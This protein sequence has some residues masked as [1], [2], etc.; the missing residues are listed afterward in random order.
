MTSRKGP[1]FR[2]TGLPADRSDKELEV[3]LRTTINENFSEKETPRPRFSTTIIPS[4]YDDLERAALVEFH[5][6]VPNFLNDLVENPLG[7]WQVEMGD[8]D[9]NFDKHFF[10]FT[11]LYQPNANPSVTADI[12]AITGLD[13]HAY[14]SWRGKGSLGRM[15]LRDFLSKDLPHCRTMIYGYNSKLSSHGIDT[16]MDYGR[17]LMEELKKIRNS[18]EVSYCELIISTPGMRLTVMEYQLR[19]RPLFFIAHSFGGIILAHCLVKAVQTNEDDHPTIA[20]LHKATYGMLLFAIPHK[21]LV[22]SDIQNMVT[23]GGTHPR[24]ALLDQIKV[25]SDLLA[26]QLVDFKNLIR[27]RKIVSFYETGQTRQL[28]FNTQAKRWERTGSFVTA[29]DTDSALLQLPDSME[30]KIPLG[31]DHSMIVKFDARQSPGYASSRDR[32]KAF[33]EDARKVVGARFYLLWIKGIPGSGKSTALQYALD[34]YHK[35]PEAG[36]N[37]FTLVF[38]FHHRGSD[39]QQTS[40]GFIRSLLCQILRQ[41]PKTLQDLVDVFSQRTHEIGHHGEGWQ[42]RR[43]ELWRFFEDSVTQILKTRQIWLFVDALD[44][45][46]GNDATDVFLRIR[47]ILRNVPNLGLNRL[48]VCFSSRRY[49]DLDP[50]GNLVI[51]LDLENQEDIS[52][53]VRQQLSHFHRLDHS[54][55]PELIV[56][57]AKSLFLWASIMVGKVLDKLPTTDSWTPLKDEIRHT[58]QELDDLYYHL[59]KDPRP[60]F[61]EIIRWICFASR[62]LL[63]DELRWAVI[64]DVDYGHTSLQACQRSRWFG[65]RDVRFEDRVRLLSHGLA[66]V[67]PQ[68]RVVRFI[69]QSV[70]DFFIDKGGFQSLIS[71]TRIDSIIEDAH[72]RLSRACIRYFAMKEISQLPSHSF[73]DLSSTFPLLDY[74]TKSWVSHLKLCDAESQTRILDSSFGSQKGPLQTWIR[75]FSMIDQHSTHCPPRGFTMLHFLSANHL[76]APLQKLLLEPGCSLEPVN[77]MDEH[78][79]TPLLCAT[80]NGCYDTAK[81]LLD[82]GRADPNIGDKQRRTPLWWAAKNGH[83]EVTR[84]LLCSKGVNVNATDFECGR[85]P[86]TWAAR[87][88]HAWVTGL[89]LGT[90]G[91]NVNARDTEY[92]RAPLTWAARNGN[93][94]VAALI[95]KSND[96]NLEIQDNASRTPIAWTAK[97]GHIDVLKLLL[98]RSLA[99][100]DTKD[101][102][103]HTPVSWAAR[104]GYA[105]VVE[106]LL[107]TSRKLGL[108][109]D[110]ADEDGRTPLSWAA[111][112][113]HSDVVKLILNIRG[114][115]IN[116][117]EG[118]HHTSHFWNLSTRRGRKLQRHLS[119]IIQGYDINS[120]DKFGRTPLGWAAHNGHTETV[121]LLIEANAKINTKDKRGRTPLSMV[122]RNYKRVTGRLL[123]LEETCAGAEDEASQTPLIL[124]SESGHYAVAKLLLESKSIDV[125]TESQDGW[126]TLTWAAKNGHDSLVKLLLDTGKI[127]VNQRTRDDWTPLLLAASK[128]HYAV[129]KLLLDRRAHIN[130]KD[131]DGWTALLFATSNGHDAVVELLLERNADVNTKGQNGRTPLLLASEKGH[132]TSVKLL[133]DMNADINAKTQKGWTPLMWATKNA[134][135]TVVKLLLDRNANVNAKDSEELLLKRKEVDINAKDHNGKTPLIWASEKGFARITDLLLSTGNADVEAKDTEGKT[136]L[137]H[138]VEGAY[139]HITKLLLKKGN[140]DVNARDD[141][142]WTALLIASKTCRK[143]ILKLILDTKKAD[144][145]CKDYWPERTPLLWAAQFG[146]A[147]IVKLL[148]KEENLLFEERDSEHDRTPLIWAALKGRRTVVKLLLESK[149]VNVNAEDCDK[150]TALLWAARNGKADVVK[151]LLSEEEIYLEAKDPKHGR[152]SLIWAAHNGRTDVV[153]AL[154]THGKINVNAKDKEGR[155]PLAWAVTKGYRTVV[156]TLLSVETVDIYSEDT[157]GRTLLS[158]AANGRFD[159]CNVAPL[160]LNKGY[161]KVDEGDHRGRTPLSWAAGHGSE[162]MI[163]LLLNTNLVDVNAK[164]YDGRTP[165]HT[166]IRYM[167]KDAVKALL[168]A[169]DIDI[170]LKDKDGQTPLSRATRGHSLDL[171][172]LLLGTGKADVNTRDDCGRTPLIWAAIEN[173]PLVIKRLLKQKEVDITASDRDGLTA[174]SWAVKKNQRGVVKLLQP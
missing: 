92:G 80:K 168:E 142:D 173:Y 50:T 114:E 122:V 33:E 1:I 110:T 25:K 85:T 153:K 62:P 63:V 154:I 81:L 145:N 144:I 24:S 119:Q 67:I 64:M 59:I 7:D 47:N 95:L 89:I 21:G 12:I 8:I 31:T 107:Q 29:V 129:V 165:I 76:F 51:N 5:Y 155:T 82:L 116:L 139:L 28:E 16:I 162:F 88:G 167:Q 13:G 10:G 6:G 158:L 56:N 71:N 157:Y 38:F 140:A 134:D 61:L 113:G 20:T 73:G 36:D 78:G 127:D 52:T 55:I 83:A 58:P 45:C 23:A 159:F 90:K 148:L 40:Y 39:L 91:V 84:L 66:E 150:L 136:A 37:P 169:T 124:A 106:L 77:S 130:A 117:T 174:L 137:L 96:I 108:D 19:Q 161:Y 53:Y 42:W 22:V 74:A 152:T 105:D 43:E 163:K 164:D 104:N 86:L 72:Q 68:T 160:L 171:M 128:G 143:G 100:I 135:D 102:E 75:V 44:E 17:E 9:I 103:G 109:I 97:N 4:C 57:N 147:T 133:L 2:V 30:E 141:E 69:H 149:K 126:T 170:N 131:T 138:A 94:E 32:L 3:A 41:N 151:L 27:D 115:D 87:N 112:N 121:R 146:Y 172:E 60:G 65:P 118:L 93:A 123:H 99:V 48:Q 54:G 111:G 46:R 26:N 35:T 18:E 132:C 70:K 15:W 101:D 79:Q 98:V 166:A 120:K 34:N 125:N 156:E 11:Q 14:G 49:P